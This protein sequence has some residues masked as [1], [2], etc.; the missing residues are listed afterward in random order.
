MTKTLSGINA[1]NLITYMVLNK[2]TK[3]VIK[4]LSLAFVIQEVIIYLTC[5]ERI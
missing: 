3:S 1:L 4:F 5:L 2:S